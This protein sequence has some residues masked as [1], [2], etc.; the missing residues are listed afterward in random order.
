MMSAGRSRP[1]KKLSLAVSART[2]A[3]AP[4]IDT[5]QPKLVKYGLAGRGSG[6]ASPGRSCIMGGSTIFRVPSRRR[7]PGFTLIELLVVVTIICM[8]FA[9]LLPAI[10]G[11]R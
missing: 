6:R 3:L 5:H 9:L 1:P 10:N 4:D 2:K 8:L 7:V 11:A